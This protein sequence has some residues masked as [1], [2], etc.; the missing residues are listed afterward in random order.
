MYDIAKAAGVSIATVARVVH[1]KGYVS[2]E[3]RKR[4][5][6]AIEQFDYIPN[7]MAQG[8]KNQRSSLIGHIMPVSDVNMIFAMISHSVEMAAGKVGYNVLSVI[9]QQD[10]DKE[11][12]LIDELLGNLPQGIVFSGFTGLDAAALHRITELGIPVV[13]I[14]RSRDIL[15]ADKVLINNVEGAYMATKYLFEKGHRRIAFVGSM[16]EQSVEKDR[17]EGYRA[18]FRE[19]GMDVPEDIV[20]LVPG[21]VRTCG[22]DAARELFELENSPTAL[23]MTSDMLVAGALQYLYS[24]GLRVP[25][26]VSVI[27]YDDTLS[28]QLAPQISTVAF[29]LEEIGNTT[30]KLLM[31]RIHDKRKVSKSVMLSPALVHRGSVREL[32]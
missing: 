16:P 7:R 4:V 8:L 17:Y 11:H 15:N 13:M 22:Y 26:D 10:K 6:R 18:V 2:E 32:R 28:R 19:N 23:F 30:M 3:S 20:R 27:G 5:E 24:R 21:Y 1:N 12:Q 25:N 14:E 29:P 9:S 31:E